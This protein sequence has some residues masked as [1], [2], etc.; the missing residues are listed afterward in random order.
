VRQFLVQGLRV[1]LLGCLAGL[2]LAAVFGRILSGMLYGISVTDA[3]A[4]GGVVFLVLAV[5]HRI[6][7]ARDSRGTPRAHEGAEGRVRRAL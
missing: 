1:S 6:V 7:A 3:S 2:A 4:L 5:C